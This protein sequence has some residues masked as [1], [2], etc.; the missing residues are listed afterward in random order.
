MN[1]EELDPV[2]VGSVVRE[3]K[4]LGRFVLLD[5]DGCHYV[6]TEYFAI[7][8][9]ESDAWKIQCKLE[10]KSRGKWYMKAT[11]GWQESPNQGNTEEMLE[12]F[13]SMISQAG[14]GG[15]EVTP[16]GIAIES[17]EDTYVGGVL[18]AGGSGFTCVRDVYLT[19]LP[20]RKIVTRVGEMAVV[21]QMAVLTLM[22]DEVW[23]ENPWILSYEGRQS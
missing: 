20:D 4:Q 18:Y 11:H 6:F 13:L 15:E 10:V 19:M 14:Q 2:N 8:L 12:K 22:Q 16:T 1:D 23:S 17:Y 21:N 3:I 9:R 7:Q 5:R